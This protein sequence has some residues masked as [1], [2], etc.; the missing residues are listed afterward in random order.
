MAERFVYTVKRVCVAVVCEMPSLDPHSGVV[1]LGLLNQPKLQHKGAEKTVSKPE[2]PFAI[3]PDG[4]VH[5]CAASGEPNSPC[6]TRRA[7]D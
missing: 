6:F 3:C 2:T 5:V 1:R 7:A 4:R